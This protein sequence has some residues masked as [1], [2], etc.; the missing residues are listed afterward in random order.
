MKSKAP[1]SL[2]FYTF[3]EKLTSFFII[4]RLTG[5]LKYENQFKRKHQQSS[6]NT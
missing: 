3:V 2:L 4:N 1:E 6:L 5:K